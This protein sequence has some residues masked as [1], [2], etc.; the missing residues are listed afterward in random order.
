MFSVETC[1]RCQQDLGD[2]RRNGTPAV[3]NHCGHVLTDSQAQADRSLR[4]SSLKAIV[5]FGAFLILLITQLSD[6]GGYFAEIRWLQAREV[7]GGS[8]ATYERVAEICMDLKKYDCAERAYAQLGQLDVRQLSRLG[9]LQMSRADY[10]GAV[11]A[12]SVYV[13][14]G[15]PDLESVYLYAKALAETGQIEKAS[16][17]FETV[18]RAK[19]EVLQI[20]VVQNYVKYLMR[21]ER[22]DQAAEVITRMRKLDQSKASFMDS[23]FRMINEKRGLRG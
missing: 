18:I 13:T 7:M 22:L 16:E 6:W 2:S 15:S 3:C 1:P 17:Q 4:M 10:P 14:A 8:I 19:P 11:R 12:Y 20:T 21:S 5:A 9:H 23:E